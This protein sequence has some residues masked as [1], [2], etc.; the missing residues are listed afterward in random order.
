MKEKLKRLKTKRYVA[1]IMIVLLFVFVLG[2][3][4]LLKPM[5]KEIKINKIVSKTTALNASVIDGTSEGVESN[6]YDE[7]KYRLTIEKES[8]DQAIIIG[9]LSEKENKYARFKSTKEGVVTENGKKITVTTKKKKV[10]IT[11]IIENAPY[12]TSI[13]PNFKINSQDENKSKIEVEPVT[14]TGKSVEG[15]VIDE[16]GTLYTGIELGL[17]SNGEEIKRTYTRSDGDYVFSLGDLNSYEVSVKEDKYKIVR[18]SE[19]TTDENR[20]ILNVVIKEVEPFKLNIKKTISKLDLTINGKKETFNYNDETTVVK[21]IK[22]AKTIEGSIYYNISIKNEGEI[23]GTLTALKDVIPDGLSFDKE[24][25][26]GWTKEGNTLFYTV[27]EGTEIDAFGKTNATLVLDIKKTDTARTYINKAIANG[28]DYKYVAYYLNNQIYREEYVIANEKIEDINPNVSNFAGWYTDKNYSNRY[29]FDKEVTKDLILFGKINNNK[30]SVT[31]IDVNPNNNAETILDIVEVNEGESVEL[32]DHPE[33]RGY[34][35]KCFELNNA[36]YNDDPIYEDTIIYTSYT[37]ND[38]D[39]VYNL[40]DGAL[41][42]DKIN[43]TTYTIR[44]SFTLN[45][46]YKQ[47]FTF[48]GWSGT[49]LTEI[50]KNV[51]ITEGSIGDREYLANYEI[52]KATLTVDPNGGKYEGSTVPVDIVRNYGT[53]ITLSTPEKNGYDFKSWILTSGGG[54]LSGSTYTFSTIDGTVTANYKIKDYTITYDL[55]GGTLS[56]P[57]PETYNIESDPITLNNPTKEGYTFIGWTGTDLTEETETVTIPTGSTG[58]RSYKANFVINSYKLTINPNGGTYNNSSNPVVIEKN[59]G[60][61]IAIDTPVRNGYQYV[62]WTL[63]GFGSLAENTYTYEA[64]DGTL[65]ADWSIITYDITYGGLTPEEE[66]ALQNP[67]TYTVEDEI[68]LTNPSSRIDGDGDIY[69]RFTGWTYGG[70]TSV[71][72]RIEKGTTGDLHFDANFA[73][74]DPDTYI[75]TY[76]LVGGTVSE[77]NPTTYTIKTGGFTLNNPSKNGYNFTGWTGTALSGPTVT[78]TVPP[79]STGDR[80]YT[81]TY[82]PKNYPINYYGITA[83]EREA[84]GNPRTYTIETPTFILENPSRVGYTFNGWTGSNGDVPSDVMVPIGSTGEKTYEA[85]FTPIDYSITYNLNGGSVSEDNPITYNIESSPITL[86]NPTKTGYDFIGWTGTGIDEPTKNITIPTGSMG[87]RSYTANYVPT[88]YI[89]NY[90][91]LDQSEIDALENPKNYTIETPTFTLENPTRVGYVFRGWSGTDI[92][93]K[94]L[95][96]TVPIGSIGERNYTANFDKAD[97]TISYTLNGG[98]LEP[99]KTNPTKYSIESDDITLNNPSKVGYTFKGWSG[100]DLTG[101][102]NTLVVI[103]HGSIGHRSFLANYDPIVYHITY[104][105]DGGSLPSGVTNPSEYTIE[106]DDITFN[107]PSKEGYTFKNYTLNNVITTS[108]PKGSTG[109]KHLV[110]TYEIEHYKVTYYNDSDKFAEVDA[111]WNTKTTVISEIPTKPHNIFLHWSEGKYWLDE[112]TTAFDFENTYIKENRNLYAVYEEVKAPVITVNPTLDDAT[113]R[114]WVCG[115]SSNDACGVTVTITNNPALTDTTGYT[116]YY[117]IGDGSAVEYTGPFPV[118]S[119]ETI[120]AFAKKSDIYSANTTA[121]IV[122][123]DTIAPTIGNPATGSMSFNMT[124]GGSAQDAG[125]G[126]KKFTLYAR[127]KTALVFDDTLTY[128]SEIFDGIRDHSEYYDHTFTGSHIKDNTEYVVKIVAEDYVGNTSEREVEITTHPYVARVVGKNGMLWYTV[129]PDTKEFVF[130]TDYLPF[131]SIQIAIDYCAEMQCTIQTNPILPVVNESV[132]VAQDQNVTIDLDGRIITSDESATIVNNGELH[133]VDR[134]PRLNAQDEHESIG[135]LVSTT[136]TA[137]VNNG[138]FILGDGSSEPS[139]TFIYPELDRP[140]IE[141]YAAAIEQN[142]TFYFFDGKLVSDTIA[143]IDKGNT[144]PITQY[145][146]N[147]AITR[148]EE[149]KIGT[150]AIV[151]DPEARIRSTYYTKLK[152]AQGDNAFDSSK[153]GTIDTESARILSKIKQAGD[154]GFIYDEVNDLIYSGNTSTSNTTALSYVKLDL[155]RETEGKFLLYDA[156]VDSYNTNSA[157]YVYISETLGNTGTELSKTTGND[158]TATRIGYLEPGKIYYI[159]FKFVKAGGDIN[160]NEI[161]KITKFQIVGER[162]QTNYLEVVEDN[163]RYN[164]EKQDDGSFKSNNDEI[165]GSYAHSYLIYDLREET[166]DI[167]IYIN[168][169]ID[170]GNVYDTGYIYITNSPDYQDQNNTNGRI[171]SINNTTPGDYLY[172]GKLT[173]G[174]VN[175]VH[176]GYYNYHGRHGLPDSFTINSVGLSKT[177]SEELIPTS[178]LEHNDTDT[179]YFEKIDYDPFTWKDLSPNGYDATVYNASINS[180]NTGYVFDGTDYVYIPNSDFNLTDYEESVYLEYSTTTVDGNDALYM[181]STNERIFIGLSGNRIYVSNYAN[182]GWY[183]KPSNFA[184]G[185]IH[186]I[187]VAHKEGNYETYFDG[188]KLTKGNASYVSGANANTYIGWNPG[189]TGYGYSGTIYN[190]KVFNKEITPDELDNTENLVLNLDGSNSKITS[191]SIYMSTN[192]GAGTSISHSYIEFDLTNATEDKYLYVNTSISCHSY[193]YGAVQVTDSPDLPSG[194][195]GREIYLSGEYNNYSSVIKLTKGRVNYVHFMYS[196]RGNWVAGKDIFIIKEVKLCNTIEDAY[197]INTQTHSGITTAYFEKPILNTSVDTIELLKNITLDT[198]IVVPQ[199]KE[200]VIDLNGFTLSSNKDDYMIKNNGKLTITDK[201]LEERRKQNIEYKT[202]QARLY[203]E[204]KTRYFEDLAEYQEYTGLCDGCSPS[205]EYIFD[206]ATFKEYDYKNDV[207]EFTPYISG[208]YK[209]E[210]WGAQ[211]AK[212][213]LGGKGA[214]TSGII[215]LSNSETLYIYVGEQSTGNTKTFNGGGSC[216]TNCTSGG[217]ATDIR[218]NNGSWDSNTGLSSRIMVAAGGAGYNTYRNG[219]AGGAGGALVGITGAGDSPHTLATQTTPGISYGNDSSKNGSFGIGGN[220]ETWGGGGSGGY[221]GGAAGKNSGTGNGGSSGTS[222]IS[223]YQGCVAISAIDDLTPRLDSNNI[224]C[225]NESALNDITCSYHYSDKIFSDTI[226]KAGNEEMPDYNSDSTMVG[227]SGNGHVRISI[228]LTDEE[229]EEIYNNFPKT[230]NVKEE[231]IFTDYITGIDIDSSIDINELTP[232]SPVSFNN[233]VEE[234]STGSITTTVANAI[235]NEQ[236]GTLTLNNSIINVNVDSKVGIVNRGLL[237]IKNSAAINANNSS[238]YG[239]YNESNGSVVFN[240]GVINAIGSSSIGL[241]NRSDTPSISGAKVITTP[242]NA[243]GVYNQALNDIT[244]SNLDISGAGMGFREISTANTI[245]ANSNIESTGSNPI[246]VDSQHIPNKFTV[247]NSNL[248]GTLSIYATPKIVTVNNSTLTTVSNSH[249]YLTINNS[250][251]NSITN[252]GQTNVNGSELTTS[253]SVISNWSGV[254]NSWN[255]ITYDSN[256]VL[257]NS[258]INSTATSAVTLITNNKH[259]IINNTKFNNINNAASTVINNTSYLTIAGNTIVDPTFGTVVSNSGV[260]TVGEGDNNVKNTYEYTFTGRQEEFIAP[261]DGLYKLETWGASGS[262]SGRYGG[263]AT[264][265]CAERGGFGGY[266]SGIVELHEGDKLYIHV[267]EE[268]MS[269]SNTPSHSYYGTYNGGGINNSDAR[270]NWYTRGAGGGATDISLSNEDNVWSYDNGNSTNRRSQTSYEQRLVVAGGGGVCTGTGNCYGGYAV[271]PSSSRLGYGNDGSGGGY[272]GGVSY[273]GGSSYV[274]NTLTNPVMIAGNAE[275][276]DYTSTGLIVGNYGNGFAKITLLSSDTSE[277][278]EK[279]S[280]SSVNYGITGTGR[281]IYYDGTITSEKAINS[282]IEKVQEDYDI[283]ISNEDNKEKMVLVA[284]ANSRPV[285]EGQE[286]YVAAIGNAKF[287]TIQNAIDASNNG[288][289]IDL[290]VDINQQNMIIIP[291]DKQITIDYN[292]HT[293]TS[294]NNNYLFKNLGNLVITDSTNTLGENISYGDKY[295]Y[296][297]GT[298]KV[299]KININDISYNANLIENN[300]G[301]LT[302][303]SVKLTYDNSGTTQGVTNTTNGTIIVKDSVLYLAGNRDL[304]VNNGNI[305]LT[306]NTISG[307]GSSAIVN[308][309]STGTAVLDGNSYTVA[310]GDSYG[311]YILYNN[312]GTST[313]KN[314]TTLIEDV[315]NTGTLTLMDNNIPSGTVSSSGLVIVDSGSYSNNFSISGS[316]KTIDNTDNLYSFIMHDG[317]INKVLNISAS[318]ITNIESGSIVVANDYAI[319]NSGSGILNLGTKDGLVDTKENTKPIITGNAYGIY[320]SNPALTFNFYDGIITGQKAYNVTI[321][322]VESGYS[323]HLDQEDGKE[324]KYLTNE[325]FFTNETQGINYSSAT[326]LNTAIT[327]GLVNNNDVIKAYRNITIIKNEDAITIPNGLKITFDINGKIVEKNNNTLF[328][329]NGE[330]DVIDSVV[331][332]TGL[333]DS[334]YGTIFVNNGLLNYISGNST[335]EKGSIESEV[336]KN[337][338]NATVNVTGGTLIKYYDALGYRQRNS[339]SIINN[340]GN[341]NVTGGNF[342][343]NSSYVNNRYDE[344]VDAEASSIYLYSSAVFVNNATGNLVVTGGVF[345]GIT[346]PSWTDRGASWGSLIDSRGELI[347]NDGIASF[348][349]VTSHN[350]RIG[351]NTN[352]LTFNNVIMDNNNSIVQGIYGQGTYYNLCNTGDIYIDDSTFTIRTSFVDNKGGNMYITDSTIDK[353]NNGNLYSTGATFI[354]RGYKN[355]HII[356]NYNNNNDCVIDIEN[357]HIYNRGSGEVIDN[358]GTIN[359]KDSTIEATNNNAI[360]SSGGTI[361]IDN[362]DVTAKN[363]VV[364]LSAATSN[365]K[366]NS[367]IISNTGIGISIASNSTLT[368]GETITAQDHTVSQTYPLIKGETYGISNSGSTVNFFDGIIKGKT[369]SINGVINNIEPGYMVIDDVEGDYK[370]NYLDRVPIIQNITQATAQDEKKYYDLESAFDDAVNGDTLQMISNYSN[371]PSDA[372]A[373][374]DYNVTFDMNGK[375]IRQSNNILITNNGT[376]N[377]ID[378]SQDKAGQLIGISGTKFIDNYGTINYT[379]GK[380]TSNIFTTYIKNN[381]TGTMNIRDNA[382]IISPIIATLIDNEGI[383]NIYNGAYLEN[384]GGTK[385]HLWSSNSGVP[386]IINKNELNIIDL[387]NDDD[388]NTSSE[389]TAPWFYSIG[390]ANPGSMFYHNVVSYYDAIIRNTSGSTTTIYGGIYNNGSTTSP[391]SGT[392]IWNSGTAT[393]KNLDNYSFCIGYNDGTLN[394]LDSHFYNFQ[395]GA[396]VSYGPLNIKDTII[397]FNA[398]SFSGGFQG[399]T[400]TMSIGDSVLDNVSITGGNHTNNSDLPI[401]SIR[402]TGTTEIKNSNLSFITET[403]SISNSG[404]LTIKNTPMNL[405]KPISNSGTL[406][407]DNSTL[408]TSSNALSSSGTINLINNTTVT[409]SEGNAIE[410]SGTLNVNSTT[411]II[412]T[413]TDP[414]YGKGINITGGTT[415]VGEIGGVPDVEDPYIEGTTYGVSISSGAKFHFYDGLIVGKKDPDAI[416]GEIKSVEGGYMPRDDE[417]T[418]PDT[419]VVTHYEYLVVNASSVAI[420]R[421][422]TIKFTTNSWTNSGQALQD[423][424]EHAIGDGT[425]VQVV[426]LIANVDLV[427]DEVSVTA[428]EPVTI[429]ANGFNINQNGTYKLSSNITLNTGG[430]V[431]GSVSKLLGDVFDIN[432]N[433]K[434]ILVYEMSDGS[435]LDTSK[436]YTLYRDGKVVGLEKEE[437]GKYRYKGDNE[438]LTSVRGRLYLDNLN[439]GSYKLVSSDNKYIEFSIDDGGNISGN[440]TESTASSSETKAEAISTAELI[441]QIQTGIERHY[442]LLLIIPLILIIISLIVII[443]KNK[444]REI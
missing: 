437:L 77:P 377:I 404:N 144:D 375:Y 35:F 81:A 141:G 226:M 293:V 128:E 368:I 204:A 316:G 165:G 88:T 140:I 117:K 244:Y 298:L 1:A 13:T 110:A 151:D 259:L 276:P 382:K 24:K 32:I 278:S 221:W 179:Y 304:F 247:N 367:S 373:V 113:N 238:T 62:G 185:N 376:L 266:A 79:R 222:Y 102:E 6:N 400:V 101:D 127:E 264:N 315:Y 291:Q 333:I 169:Q 125:S 391:D 100:T 303:D 281:F 172:E 384:I 410:T 45:N 299:S 242:S 193:D 139:E 325:P 10:T 119:N 288:D 150:L 374:N 345:D 297:E 42:E 188:V 121:E 177:K 342:Y 397:N 230:Y 214:Y 66:L 380:L 331:D 89:I 170:T 414:L 308:N 17:S 347:Y 224:Q 401:H 86:N 200:V 198:S 265:M 390:N 314:M 168:A 358:A 67:T 134:N 344:R 196:K 28:E 302:L 212:N 309:T 105:Y 283:Y 322:E 14:I 82:S 372:T 29:D 271:D 352:S 229:E 191:D 57:N 33:Y 429:N 439:K 50:T 109:D 290:L 354:S 329:N 180:E 323:I 90:Y 225:T 20:R 76:D 30:Y 142:D 260:L 227:N 65:T 171:M 254:S 209:I 22:N 441:L 152:V 184:D 40:D 250:S 106:S 72:A 162:E 235:L 357:S 392:I 5:L 149:K 18:Y 126:V 321:A 68:D 154:Y 233:E 277:V 58:N 289:E 310:G 223:G 337:N 258:V 202:E 243:T 155:T 406:T 148:E 197:S 183:D 335:S 131:D 248:Y 44:D 231:P 370:T 47:G 70:S 182:A 362:S 108:I 272:Y 74:V 181:G 69:E 381:S 91:G 371:L 424:V 419:G 393:I 111:D 336:I 147:V 236:Y 257:N 166:E 440:V 399:N 237:T 416:F 124:V 305:T 311:R 403:T 175:Y 363:T 332:S 53:V 25:N 360:N 146:Y 359:I 296:N 215:S 334:Y 387:N 339:G 319:N 353:V 427:N 346:S 245:V 292:G 122:N 307:N 364:N 207:Q 138:H 97:Y 405:D 54:S 253:S 85:H 313:I 418:D 211:G 217:G 433:P 256:M 195:S 187:L 194:A 249:G 366:N 365:I 51:T 83:A 388:E 174:E 63:T 164:F 287:T 190:V 421:V 107:S 432:N 434:D 21:S 269:G 129:D 411:R 355:S 178:T 55:S 348:T 338:E 34:T 270:F 95:S 385:N 73:H 415:N 389:L 324:I 39:I 206:K 159:Y 341:A 349:G 408:T 317:T 246:Y 103:P 163:Y 295:I 132:I 417:S 157:G 93:D 52:N 282:D 43:P 80:S 326:A 201:T 116:L 115:D 4:S 75:I 59:Y 210:T 294:Y 267:G 284:N 26:P 48:I 104:D 327:N 2:L 251:L 84:L 49:D 239:I 228:V 426:D 280:L 218:L 285:A 8:D 112:D 46:P 444:E 431:G 205:E 234:T 12:G 402:V 312:G 407:I 383:L 41:E 15:K 64:G 38:Y 300:E 98:E 133:I 123:V 87:N 3:T 255:G 213:D 153:T 7:I 130:T 442:Y 189:N 435:K 37:V 9:T 220:G 199:E 379:G 23:K 412:A 361:N 356:R 369:N 430:S 137:V 394:I 19:E 71:N 343:A 395:E 143:M 306:N 31:F 96:V 56:A 275:M 156:Y 436:T 27:L 216:G 279:P 398:T 286:S 320:T 11:V 422:G 396:L 351:D 413:S 36:C 301:T 232:T 158:V 386:M 61:V 203:E 438:K 208:N 120:T 328:I 252:W 167:N 420:A 219:Y 16:N 262:P 176:F 94:S 99:G 378:S 241:L 261:E 409:A 274:S 273:T 114:T 340:D 318:G 263:C 268:G 186:S 92:D 145:S 161:F 136:G 118:Y 423:A 350:S 428:T 78:V 240:G 160:P 173:H 192:E 443:R 60:T 135:K 425:N 330:L